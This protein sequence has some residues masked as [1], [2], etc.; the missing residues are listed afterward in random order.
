MGPCW[1]AIW[2]G[3]TERSSKCQVFSAPHCAARAK[4]GTPIDCSLLVFQR[5]VCRSEN[6]H[7]GRVKEQERRGGE[8]APSTVLDISYYK[9]V[10]GCPCRD[11]RIDTRL[12]VGLI[13]VTRCPAYHRIASRSLCIVCALLFWSPVSSSKRANCA[14]GICDYFYKYTPC[15]RF[16]H[17]RHNLSQMYRSKLTPVLPYFYNT[18]FLKKLVSRIYYFSAAKMWTTGRRRPRCRV[19]ECFSPL[20]ALC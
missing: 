3:E 11:S 10:W 20:Q 4:R 2:I 17:I 7:E 6:C 13:M 18:L 14:S 8:T 1:R 9:Y 16:L 12:C 15:S 5:T 19:N